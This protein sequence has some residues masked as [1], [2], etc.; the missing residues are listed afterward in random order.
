MNS[1]NIRNDFS[2]HPFNVCGIWQRSSRYFACFWQLLVIFHS[3]CY[4][5]RT[6]RK[7]KLTW[8]WKY[9]R[10]KEFRTNFPT[11]INL[12]MKFMPSRSL[13]I[14]NFYPRFKLEETLLFFNI[15]SWKFQKKSILYNSNIM[16]GDKLWD[17]NCIHTYCCNNKWKC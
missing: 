16:I 3:I 14:S 9:P 8:P 12:Y 4:L 13:Q 17:K 1:R 15:W 2:N 5:T 7:S 11:F 6:N 10:P